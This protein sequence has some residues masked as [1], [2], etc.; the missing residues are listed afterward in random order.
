MFDAGGIP[1]RATLSVSFK[2]FRTIQEQLENP[3]LNSS[4]KT[5]RR[6]LSADES[7]WALSEKEY[8]EARH[9]RKLAQFNRIENPRLLKSGVVVLLPPL[10]TLNAME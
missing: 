4:D 6:V 1:V 7:L 8:G 3:S 2:Q 5:K 9:W 10:D